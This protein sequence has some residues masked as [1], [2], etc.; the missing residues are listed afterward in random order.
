MRYLTVAAEYTGSCVKDD[1]QGQVECHELLSDKELCQELE[2]WN[3]DY[4]VIIPLD[5]DERDQRRNEIDMLDKKGILLAKK[6]AS[7]IQGGA[8]VRYYSEGLLKYLNP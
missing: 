2:K 3:A 7:A 8:K 5:M 1:F 6:L 4:K